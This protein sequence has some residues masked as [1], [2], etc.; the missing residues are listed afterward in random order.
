MAASNSAMDDALAHFSTHAVVA[1]LCRDNDDIGPDQ[2]KRALCSRLCIREADIKVVRHKPED[3]FIVFEHPHHRDAALDLHRLPAGNIVIRILPWR[4]LPYGDH[5]DLRHHVRICLEGIPVHAWNESIAKRAVARSCDLDYVDPRSLRRD[6]RALCPDD[7][8]ALCLWAW[9][10]NPSDIP[11]VTWLTLT[12]D[13]VTAHD[14][15]SPPKGRRGLTFRVLVHLDLIESPVDGHGTTSTRELTWHYGVV[16]GE[17]RPRERHASPPPPDARHRCHR[18]DE[19]D[20]DHRGRRRDSSRNWGSRLLR[21]LSRAPARER[22]RSESRHGRRHDD[23]SHGGHRRRDLLEVA[24]GVAAAH[25]HRPRDTNDYAASPTT[26]G[27]SRERSN[28]RRKEGQRRSPARLEPR[29]PSSQNRRQTCNPRCSPGSTN[30]HN[31]GSPSPPT[32]TESPPRAI[33]PSPDNSPM[34]RDV[35]LTPDGTLTQPAHPPPLVQPALPQRPAVIGCSP[36]RRFRPGV[37]YVR[38]R[39]NQTASRQPRDTQSSPPTELDGSRLEEGSSMDPATLTFVRAV[40]RPLPPALLQA[41][42]RTAAQAR[43]LPRRTVPATRKSTRIAAKN[44]PRGDAH[45]KARQVL[46]KK[47]GVPE[48][49][50]LSPDDRFL[51]YLGLF[52]GPLTNEAIQAMTALCGLDGDDGIVTASQA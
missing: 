44:W 20:D 31:D 30:R 14:G 1:C 18:D 3:F 22:E 35:L 5:C 48:D 45:A 16:D 43:G 38:R 9:T 4:V 37:V 21:S 19:D 2:V 36:A 27:R 11:K 15:P 50:A 52:Q 32:V 28:R 8:R 7:T 24:N 29:E 6:S 17:R 12:G 25:L 33:P 47:L 39:P 49:K 10:Y 23:R 41:P 34:R 26:R 46:M 51:Q 42:P 40:S 13:V